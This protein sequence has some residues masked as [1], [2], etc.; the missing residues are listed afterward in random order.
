MRHRALSSIRSLSGRFIDEDEF[1]Y[2]QD[3]HLV[4]AVSAGLKLTSAKTTTTSSWYTVTWDEAVW[5][6][7]T[8]WWTDTTSTTKQRLYVPYDGYYIAMFKYGWEVSSTG[9]RNHRVYHNAAHWE[10]YLDSANSYNHG[11][12][13]YL[14]SSVVGDYFSQLVIQYSGGDLDFDSKS[15]VQCFRLAV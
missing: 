1:R 4:T 6:Y 10:E 5:Q 14:S 3:N 12:M 13:C 11:N 8:G 7:P 2:L 15:T 9:A